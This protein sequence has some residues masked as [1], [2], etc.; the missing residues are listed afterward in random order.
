[1]VTLR[2]IGSGHALGWLPAVAALA[3]ATLAG[4]G[5]AA[6]SHTAGAGATVCADAAHVDRLT[7]SRTSMNPGR[8]AFPAE[9]TI[10][11]PRQAQAVARALCALPA[12]PSG[13][14]SCPADLGISYRLHFAAD[15]RRFPPVTVQATGCQQVHGLGRARWT[16]RSPAFW[17][18]LGSAA[19]IRHASYR[20][21]QGTIAS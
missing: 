6:A 20:T 17:A 8:F 18:V 13:A 15:G 4:C 21:F 5:Q 1:M 3:C 7:I 2:R 16:V 10:T 19:G 9:I 12:M 11:A 14:I